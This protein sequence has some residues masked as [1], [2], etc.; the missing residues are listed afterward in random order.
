MESCPHTITGI[1]SNATDYTVGNDCHN[2]DTAD[3]R[4]AY[5]ECCE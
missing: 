2:T 1:D 5:I 4:R 3:K